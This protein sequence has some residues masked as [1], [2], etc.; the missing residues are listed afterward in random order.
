MYAFSGSGD[1]VS[2]GEESF[3]GTSRRAGFSSTTDIG[4][5]GSVV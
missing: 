4:I 1:R 2:E 3:W 5:A